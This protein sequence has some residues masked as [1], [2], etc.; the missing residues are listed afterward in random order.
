MKK[1]GGGAYAGLALV[2]VLVL[3]A[4]AAQAGTIIVGDPLIPA[5][6]VL[7]NT[8]HLAFVTST[9]TNATSTDIAYYNSFVAAAAELPGSLVQGK[10]WTWNAIGSTANVNAI[11]NA[12]A[13]AN[14]YRVDG[15]RLSPT[16]YF[17]YTPSTADAGPLAAAFNKYQNNTTIP[18]G[19]FH[20]WT[21]TKRNG[22]K[23][24]FL[25]RPLGTTTPRYGTPN[26][27][28]QSQWI[29]A[30]I[31]ANTNLRSMYA[32][33]ELLT[34]TPEPATMAL[35]ALGGIGLLLGRKRR[36]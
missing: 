24:P 6:L 19:D 27:T 11:V 17:L 9:T 18:G 32:L 12:P 21:G 1:H 33:S 5:G 22:V 15:V 13:S 34:I 25:P 31:E 8:F 30:G 26:N 36:K 4:G 16:N 28:F 23:D 10:G 35:L 3:A 2:A 29:E 20:V 14:V 7:G